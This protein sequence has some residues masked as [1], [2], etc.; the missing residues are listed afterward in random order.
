MKIRTPHKLAKNLINICLFILFYFL[1]NYI[2]KK[3]R[4]KFLQY[5]FKVKSLLL[6][7]N[8][9]DR[10]KKLYFEKIK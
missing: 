3:H 4:K 6:C 8:F 5:F 1:T 10:N 7:H 9:N 2:R